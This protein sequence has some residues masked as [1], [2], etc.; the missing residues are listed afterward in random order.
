MN[1]FPFPSSASSSRQVSFVGLW[2]RFQIPVLL[3]VTLVACIL[4]RNYLTHPGLHVAGSTLLLD[5]IM[6]R[7]AWTHRLHM[8]RSRLAIISLA[9]VF[10]ASN[11]T[12]LYAVAQEND[13]PLAMTVASC[14]ECFSVMTLLM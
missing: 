6:A 5:I 1:P 13:D 8:Q 4:L 10:L 11:L 3:A 12:G 9:F 7:Y 14:E 2:R